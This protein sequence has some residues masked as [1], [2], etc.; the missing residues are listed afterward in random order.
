MS[1]VWTPPRSELQDASLVANPEAAALRRSLVNH[2]ASVKSAGMLY[3]LSAALLVLGGVAS[4]AS[5]APSVPSGRT[6]TILIAVFLFVMGGFQLM[7]GFG[8]RRLK[9]WARLPAA[10]MSAIGLLGFP[11]GTLVNAYILYLVLSEKGS[12]VLSEEYKQVIAAT[13]DIKP[14]TPLI[15]WVFLSLLVLV[16]GFVVITVA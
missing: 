15:V 7:V 8:L 6:A 13:P 12:T 14:R 2:E 4:L 10:V 11:V 5:Q 16:A 3:F 1:D 9:Y